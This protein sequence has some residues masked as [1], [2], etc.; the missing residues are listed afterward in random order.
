[1]GISNNLDMTSPACI[2]PAGKLAAPRKILIYKAFAQ[3]RSTSQASVCS[4][5]RWL[6]AVVFPPAAP[7]RSKLQASTSSARRW[8]FAGPRPVGFLEMPIFDISELLEMPIL[9][10]HAPDLPARYLPPLMRWL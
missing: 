4:A 8:S 2:L 3:A 7:A 9:Y 1:V 6:V 10:F 5:H